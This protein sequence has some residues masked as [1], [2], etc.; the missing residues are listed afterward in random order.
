MTYKEGLKD[1]LSI[2]FGYFPVGLTFGVYMTSQGFSIFTSTIMSILCNTATGQFIGVDSML[3]QATYLSIFFAM[4][5]INLRMFVLGIS[6]SQRLE[7][8]VSLVKRLLISF[9]NTDEVFSIAIRKEGYINSDYFLGLFTLPG[10][11]WTV[12]TV[13][14][15]LLAN[16]LPMDFLNTCKISVYAMFIS[17]LIPPIKE[18]KP[19]LGCIL[20]SLVL[21]GLLYWI[22]FLKENIDSA[23]SIIICTLISSV[24]AVFLDEKCEKN[25]DRE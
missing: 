22:P 12:G 6:L 18:S 21:N 13:L 24:I 23:F 8:N 10:I 7:P 11:G 14:G 5:L 25:S 9:A 15:M 3:N 19:V 16:V 20:I 2:F 4:F 1:G 17:I